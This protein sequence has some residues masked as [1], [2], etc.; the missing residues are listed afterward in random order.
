MGINMTSM[1]SIEVFN[2]FVTN[3]ASA[4][5]EQKL[6]DKTVDNGADNVRV[7]NDTLGRRP[8]LIFYA[9]KIHLFVN[10]ACIMGHRVFI[11]TPI[12]VK[13]VSECTS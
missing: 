6:S 9:L 7:G 5:G 2:M 3:N 1:C 8:L 11:F 13:H 10:R 4:I 12:V